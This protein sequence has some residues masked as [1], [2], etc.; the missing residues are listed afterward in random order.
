MS[1][2]GTWNQGVIRKNNPFFSPFR[3]T[4]ETPFYGNNVDAVSTVRE[5]YEMAASSPG[6][7]ITSLPVKDPERIGLDCD[8]RVLLFND[9]AVYGRCAAARRI[10][11]QPGIEKDEYTTI[12]REAVYKTRFRNLYQAEAVIGLA[13]DFMVK[14][15]LCVP[16]DHE[17]ILYNWL[18]NFQPINEKYYQM[19][20]SSHLLENEGDIFVFADPEWSDPRFPLGL[21]FFDP[22]A[23]CAA[24][25]GMRY[26]GEY[27]KGT[28]TLAWNIANKNGYVSCHGGLK[29]YDLHE[30]GAY[31]IAFFG[32]SGS[33]K[34]TLTHAKHGG[35]YD[36][37]ILH[38]DAFIISK[39]NGSSIALEPTYFDKT[40]DYPSDFPDNAYLLTV[41]NNGATLNE[42][43]EIVLVPEDMRNGNGRAIKSRYW[44]PNRVDKMEEPIQTI[45]WLMQDPTLPPLLKI[46]DPVTAS[47]FGATLATKRTS[48]ER[49]AEGVDPNALVIEPYANPFRTFPLKED[50]VNF[51]SLFIERGVDCYIFN[52]GFFGSK[53]IP[54][55]VTLGLL[56]GLVE[57]TLSFKPFGPFSAI[58][59]AEVEGFIPQFD[60]LNYRNEF[61]KRLE[62]RVRF[63]ESKKTVSGGYDA[64]PEEAE[65]VL[66]HMIGKLV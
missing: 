10:F 51:K 27:K 2:R 39:A 19:Y 56:E 20:Q 29:K 13:P 4:I 30:K 50:F 40:A 31:V 28:L 35:K 42:K 6:T 5:A 11:G 23:N 64:L 57:K 44:A 52:T 47:T 55:E 21:S 54:K 22:K 8:A 53:K 61:R 7:I 48:A 24:I 43:G 60:D 33:G 18:L 49:L 66:K 65:E 26:F 14:A 17:N 41:Q 45:V 12:L 37:S 58:E 25:L 32:L 34:S 36:I 9:G 62:D 3:V 63:I 59:I 15:H 38:D 46:N 1:T 16:E